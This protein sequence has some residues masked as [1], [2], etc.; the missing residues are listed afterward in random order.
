MVP[1]CVPL[2]FNVHE[3][4]TNTLYFDLTKS[5]HFTF[6]LKFVKFHVIATSN[7]TEKN[8]SR[9]MTSKKGKFTWESRETSETPEVTLI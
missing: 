2:S 1:F 8:A 4:L 9:E 3:I 5:K 6:Y 7:S